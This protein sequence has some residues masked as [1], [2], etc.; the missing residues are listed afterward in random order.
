MEKNEYTVM[1]NIEG[2]YW[3]YIALREMVYSSI[4]KYRPQKPH[5][6]LLDAGCGTGGILANAKEYDA[7]GFDISDEA[8]DYCKKRGL[9]N[10]AQASVCCL[11]YESCSFDVLVSLDVL[12]NIEEKDNKIALEEFYR[13]L[14][15]GGILVLNLP[16]YNFLQSRH[17]RAVH[18]KHRFVRKELKKKLESAGFDI[19]QI[20]YRNS[21]LFPFLAL[22]RLA[23]KLFMKNSDTPK[24]DLNPLPGPINSALTCLLS[25]EKKAILAGFNLGFGLSLFC[26]A[27][28]PP[29]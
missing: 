13:V 18:I 22:L 29:G 12:C 25:L 17:D 28:K 21:I 26:V 9:K 16:A 11:P 20:T 24:S 23:E 1:Y 19:Q 10:I 3:W 6:R 8:I 5:L 2:N 27:K 14:E 15:E 4:L 7:Y